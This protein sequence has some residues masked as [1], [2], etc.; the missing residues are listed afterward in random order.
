MPRL[1]RLKPNPEMIYAVWS[2]IKNNKRLFWLPII[3]LACILLLGASFIF[4]MIPQALNGTQHFSWLTL[5]AGCLFLLIISYLHNLFTATGIL[6]LKRQLDNQPTSL[7]DCFAIIF[8]KSPKIIAWSIISATIGALCQLL[9]QSHRVLIPIPCLS[10]HNS[11][12][13]LSPERP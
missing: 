6:F 12:I 10:W 2:I 3:N 9:E 11:I 1:N 4:F 13:L 7:S 5:L 8:A